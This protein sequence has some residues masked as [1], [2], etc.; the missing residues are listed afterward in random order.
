MRVDKI[1]DLN[2][3][4]SKLIFMV[5]FNGKPA[6]QATYIKKDAMGLECKYY[7]RVFKKLRN[8][9]ETDFK[10]DLSR[11]A[12]GE[13]I[14]GDR[15]AQLTF[16]DTVNLDNLVDN[17]GRPLSEIY[18][19]VVKRNK[20][21]EKWYKDNNNYKGEDIEFSHCFGPV[22]SGLDLLVGQEDYNVHR[23]HNHLSNPSIPT[24]KPIPKYDNVAENII[25]IDD[26]Y[27]YGDIVEFNP[28]TFD[29]TVISKVYHRF[30]T[31]QRELSDSLEYKFYN[32]VSDDYESVSGFTAST[33]ALTAYKPEGYYYEPH[34][35]I[36][37][38]NIQEEANRFLAPVVKPLS[39]TTPEMSSTGITLSYAAG[40]G[41]TLDGCTLKAKPVA[42]TYDISVTT[43]SPSGFT[44][45]ILFNECSCGSGGGG[46]FDI[47]NV[48]ITAATD[49]DYYPG[50]VF[51]ICQ[52]NTANTSE[53]NVY[54][55]DVSNVEYAEVEE[56]GV[57]KKY[58]VLTIDVE[59]W[60]I[61]SI[62]VDDEFAL[63]DGSVPQYAIYN[64]L[65]QTFI[66]KDVILPSET[67]SNAST[68]NMP[69]S[70]GA[71]YIHQNVTFFLRRQDPFGVYGLQDTFDYSK[72]TKY[73]DE[74]EEEFKQR[75]N[76]ERYLVLLLREREVATQFLK[77]VATD[78]INNCL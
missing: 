10:S 11:Q 77:F 51:G 67:P 56:D 1:G 48:R 49:Y 6:P 57:I 34:Y 42:G 71:F 25:T 68:Y 5:N 52:F 13:N 8:I 7:F 69:F 22:T 55:G 20:G 53:A 66:W 14:Y 27:F 26:E 40:A 61:D 4:N 21:W 50:D 41:T 3:E 37:L 62:S 64:P 78:I 33:S 32:L 63:T 73:E 75:V 16:L 39:G 18:L 59:N 72:E 45:E 44:F 70:N 47:K 58:P 74:T 30:N 54:W 60:P 28:N 38:H 19:T 29:E 31:A 24:P 23:L 76:P 2:R 17:L 43:N 46:D 15:I 9:D 65:E 36:V 12:F 35:K